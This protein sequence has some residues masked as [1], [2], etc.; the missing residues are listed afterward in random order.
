MGFFGAADGANDAKKRLF[1]APAV[2]IRSRTAYILV[3][4]I[5]RCRVGRGGEYYDVFT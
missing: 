1:R 2:I 4:I 5:R 3:R